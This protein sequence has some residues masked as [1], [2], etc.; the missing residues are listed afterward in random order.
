MADIQF[1]DV[2]NER[3]LDVWSNFSF[4]KAQPT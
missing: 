4:N 3:K 2:S 1:Q